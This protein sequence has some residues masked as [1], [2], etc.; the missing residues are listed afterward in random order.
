MRQSRTSEVCSMIEYL[1]SSLLMPC[2]QSSCRFVMGAS[3]ASAGRVQ[4]VGSMTVAI[5]VAAIAEPTAG[6]A[7]CTGVAA[8]QTKYASI[9]KRINRT[10][11][12]PGCFQKKAGVLWYCPRE[13]AASSL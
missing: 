13:P 9:M 8:V 6:A 4:C 12:G 3:A 2:T 11:G 5:A 7:A 10:R 1:Q